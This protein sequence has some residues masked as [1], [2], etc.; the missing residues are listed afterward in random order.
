MNFF[1]TLRRHA[2]VSGGDFDALFRRLE[3]PALPAVASRLLAEFHQ[4]EPDLRRL[5]QIISADVDLATRVLR[6]VNSSLYALPEPMRGLQQAITWLG[7]EKLRALALSYSLHDGIPRPRGGLFRHQAYWTDSLVRAL[8]ARAFARH[9]RV[10]DEDEVFTVMLL[11][12]VAL[13]VLLCDWSSYYEDVLGR[14]NSEPA[15]LSSLEGDVFGWD[16]AR[17]G[18]WILESWSFP[19]EMVALV[20]AHNLTLAELRQV[21]LLHTSALALALASQLPSILRP[22]AQRARGLVDDCRAAAGLGPDEMERVLAGVAQGYGE[23]RDLFGL[24]DDA[25]PVS[26]SLLREHLLV[27]TGGAAI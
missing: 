11:S 19:E 24:D 23:I 20:A 1:E 13:P 7:L 16:H 22:D 4:P 3:I 18:A 8:L 6:T 10:G 21:D 26:L 12:D 25:E 2:A 14:W 17:A 15:R 9:L 5:T 27:E